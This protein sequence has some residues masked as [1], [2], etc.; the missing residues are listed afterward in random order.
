M[1]EPAAMTASAG[2][3]SDEV[4]VRLEVADGLGRITLARGADHNRIDADVITQLDAAIGRCAT[5]SAVRAVLITAEG[6]AFTVGGDL[7][8]F[9]GLD[10]AVFSDRI[11]RLTQR[12]HAVIERM[13]T[14]DPP[15][16]VA[17]HGHAAGGGLGIV[18]A[19]DI[20]IAADT[21]RFGLGFAGVGLTGDGGTTWFLPRVAGR[22]LAQRLFY[23]GERLDAGEA[24]EAGIVTEVCPAAEVVA[25]AEAIALRL[26]TG[27]TRAFGGVKRLLAASSSATLAEQLAAESEAMRLAA[28]TPDAVE[29]VAAALDGRAPAF[30]GAISGSD[31]SSSAPSDGVGS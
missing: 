5:S 15:V 24:L 12:Y 9:G 17:V 13:V 28:L 16:L 25:R 18:L 23:L 4:V 2:M 29:G 30:S 11:G 31:P 3:S 8:M 19:A 6:P 1:T 14:M 20:A 21:A 7:T 10:A 26:A 22:R 27:P